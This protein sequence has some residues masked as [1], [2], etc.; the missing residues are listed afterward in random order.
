MQEEQ[1]EMLQE[2]QLGN[3]WEQE[4]QLDAL[5][6][7]ELLQIVQAVELQ[8]MQSA[9]EALQGEHALLLRYSVLRQVALEQR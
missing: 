8:D 5:R 2:K 3:C 6:K 4:V 9:K 7:E 1:E